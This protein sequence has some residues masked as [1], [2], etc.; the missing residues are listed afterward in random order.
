MSSSSITVILGR[1]EFFILLYMCSPWADQEFG[2]VMNVVRNT[3][4][5]RSASLSKRGGG[6]GGTHPN[7]FCI[8]KMQNPAFSGIL[9]DINL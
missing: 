1:C 9:C 2:V 4:R 7:I 8:G 5:A 6:S 3:T